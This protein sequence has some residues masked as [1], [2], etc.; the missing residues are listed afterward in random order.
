VPWP[1]IGGKLTKVGHDSNDRL[2]YVDHLEGDG[3]SI[4]EHVC[5]MGL[6]GTVLKRA[7]S[8][9]GGTVQDQRTAGSWFY[10]VAQSFER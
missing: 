1:F 3:T 2:Q 7:D 10:G 9:P 5:R 6:E 4:F 8:V